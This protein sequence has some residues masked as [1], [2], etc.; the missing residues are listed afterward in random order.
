MAIPTYVDFIEPL[1]R[2]LSRQQQPVPTAQAANAAA[3]A[4]G[5]TSEERLARLPS[6]G[7]AV[8]RN[9]AGWAHDRLKRAG[10][11]S[12]P[13]RG[14]WQLT[15]VGREYAARN[16]TLSQ[17]QLE[18]LAYVDADSRLRPRDS[19]GPAAVVEAIPLAEP[20][21]RIDSALREI[22]D[23]VAAELLELLGRGSP[24][25]F[26]QVVLDLLHEM[27]YGESPAAL[28]R[29]GRSGDGGIDGVI[30]LDRLGLERVYVQAKRW[31]NSVGSPQVQGFLGALR[32][33]GAEKGVLITTGTF[34]READEAAARTNGKLVLVDG[35][36]LAQLMIEHGV[37]IASRQVSIPKVD[38][39]YFPE[40]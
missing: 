30:A 7:Q 14:H 26:E 23:S 19:G 36:R 12:S 33:Q 16:Q 20:N 17:Q 11:S 27:G 39:D 5:I 21:E 8:Y 9:R 25:F 6:G 10:L 22:R 29:V 1:L 40:E 31:A 2:Y 35:K 13:K 28:R 4:L 3:D 15:P 32:L 18:E 24:T 37:G 38:S 34:T